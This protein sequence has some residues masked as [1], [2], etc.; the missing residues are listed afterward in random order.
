MATSTHVHNRDGDGVYLHREQVEEFI[1]QRAASGDA[2]SS[3]SHS[4]HRIGHKNQGRIQSA[5][6]KPSGLL[7]AETTRVACE[8][9]QQ[10]YVC[11]GYPL[12]SGTAGEGDGDGQIHEFRCR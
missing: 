1:N 10:D 4:N 7:D 5:P 6:G 9:Y 11:F 12:P 2:T 3:S 8:I